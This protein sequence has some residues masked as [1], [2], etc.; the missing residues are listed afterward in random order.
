MP[1]WRKQLL[2]HRRLFWL[3]NPYLTY[4]FKACARN[5]VKRRKKIIKLPSTI[6]TWYSWFLLKVWAALIGITRLLRLVWRPTHYLWYIFKWAFWNNQPKEKM[7]WNFLHMSK[8]WKR[9]KDEKPAKFKSLVPVKQQHHQNHSQEFYV[10]KHK[11]II[12]QS[13]FL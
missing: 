9:Y 12:F 3:N 13:G 1:Y 10:G 11:T 4:F 8:L 5:I 7:F 2:I 6:I